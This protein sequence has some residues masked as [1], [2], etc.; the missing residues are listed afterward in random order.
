MT[1]SDLTPETL[2][3]LAEAALEDG[4]PETALA[5]CQRMLHEDPSDVSAW[6]LEGEALR[7]L[8]DLGNAEAALRRTLELS[9]D[10]PGAWCSLAALLFD[11]RRFEEAA[12]V[13]QHA[14]RVAPFFAS[15]YYTRAMLRERR[16]D[17]DGA[18]R[19]YLRASRIDSSYAPPERLSDDAILE[20]VYDIT[21]EVDPLAAAWLRQAPTII[22]DLPDDEI[23]EAYEPPASPGDVLGHLAAPIPGSL[24]PALGLPPTVLLYRRNIERNLPDR[25]DLIA[26][27]QQ[28]VIEQVQSWLSEQ[29][30]EA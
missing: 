15:P 11:D 17:L 12:L 26:A 22:V 7:D 20:L 4:S 24:G 8:G 23:C 30:C 18:G 25:A 9:H 2:H 29:I 28:G 6:Y 27:L 10:H 1:A 21:D 16:G 13:T 5:I 3:E 19:D 14:I